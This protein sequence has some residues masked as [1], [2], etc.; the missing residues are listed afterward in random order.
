MISIII[1]AYNSEEYLEICI[2]SILVQTYKN[3]EIIIVNDGSTDNTGSVCNQI[4]L[5]NSSRIKVVHQ[6]NKG[7]GAAR[8]AG[9]K[10]ARGCYIMFVDSDDGLAVNTLEE[11]YKILNNHP[12]IDFLQFP[13]YYKYGASDAYLKE[14]NPCLYD[15]PLT[16]KNLILGN[17][18]ISW[19]VCDKIFRADVLKD[20]K[21]RED[22]KFED[23]YF[24]MQLIPN[25][26]S[27]YISD[28][29][30]Y[31]YYHRENSTTTSKLNSAKEL[32]TLEVLHQI[33]KM[34]DPVKDKGLFYRYI[35]RVVNIE[36]SLRVNFNINHE[37]F[38]NY[39][40]FIKIP[41]VLKFAKGLKN[42]IKI[43]IYKFH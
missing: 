12:N 3:F 11:N 32:N 28:Q 7:Q 31:Y 40:K 6:A 25:I 41:D 24:M 34:I 30:I 10:I 27:L 36:K 5:D 19:I 16:F 26:K 22:I 4:A 23:N 2:Q 9:L 29:G 17:G 21:F 14:N 42:K 37:G 18:I 39:K 20:L 1:P 15:D 33:L 43:I 38:H 13:V 35:L 8:N